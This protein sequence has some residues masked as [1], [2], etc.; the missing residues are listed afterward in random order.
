MAYGMSQIPKSGNADRGQHI[1]TVMTDFLSVC[2]PK[3]GGEGA[4]DSGP[5]SGQ[6]NSPAWGTQ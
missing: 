2:V 5:E 3:T 1:E 4:T 6:E